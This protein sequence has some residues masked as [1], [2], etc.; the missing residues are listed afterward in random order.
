MESQEIRERWE[1]KN[2]IKINKWKNDVS[3][4]SLFIYFNFC[5]TN[6]HNLSSLQQHTLTISQFFKCNI[7]AGS[8]GF[9]AQSLTKPKSRWSRVTQ[10]R[11][12][13]GDSRESWLPNSCRW[14]AEL[15]LTIL[16]LSFHLLPGN[17]LEVTFS[18][19]RP[20][21]GTSM[22]FPS[23]WAKGSSPLPSSNLSDICDQPEEA[24]CISQLVNRLEPPSYLT[25]PIYCCLFM[26]MIS[27]HIHNPGEKTVNLWETS[28]DSSCWNSKKKLS[29]LY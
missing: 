25:F 12:F 8:I 13:P 9:F 7:Q 5:I 15:F 23:I 19:A 17:E 22:W 29:W 26:K 27:H 18:D 6:Y 2:Y 16:K 14:L 20:L 21:S 10:A 24:I 1:K 4:Q 3:G 28:C 11:F